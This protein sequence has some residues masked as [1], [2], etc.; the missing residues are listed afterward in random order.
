MG[1]KITGISAVQLATKTTFTANATAN[2]KIAGSTGGGDTIT[3]GASSQSI[4]SGG[5]KSMSSPARRMPGRGSAAWGRAANWKSPR[6]A[7]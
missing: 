5:A 6:V 4:L 3:L 2:L 7:R 1:S